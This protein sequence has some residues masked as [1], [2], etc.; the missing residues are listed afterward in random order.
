MLYVHYISKQKLTQ[1]G[2][3][4]KPGIMKLLEEIIE[5][6]FF[7]IGISNGFLDMTQKAQSAKNRMKRQS[8]GWEKIIADSVSDKRLVSKIHKEPLQLN[9]KKTI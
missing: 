8:A 3:K 6:T 2:L 7:D 1:N 5:K 4:V 9:S